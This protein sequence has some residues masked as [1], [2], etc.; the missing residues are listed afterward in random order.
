MSS[1][2]SFTL[3]E[4]S[5]I[6]S[7]ILFLK[8]PVMAEEVASSPATL[9]TTVDFAATRVREDSEGEGVSNPSVTQLRSLGGMMKNRR[10]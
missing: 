7:S 9:L 1:C 8:N 3:F 2:V 4:T 6:L 10:F 5:T